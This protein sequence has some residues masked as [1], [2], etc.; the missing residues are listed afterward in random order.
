MLN[1]YELGYAP[2][3][4]EYGIKRYG[5]ETRRLYKVLENNLSAPTS[6]GFL[7]GD[8]LTV[9]DIASWGWICSAAWSGVD[10]KEFPKLLEWR[11]RL[12]A[13]DGFERGRNVP[14][15]QTS[16]KHEGKSEE[17][18]DAA[19]KAMSGWIMKGMADDSKK[20]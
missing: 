16:L 18:L 7:V 12:L 11:T 17:E 8:K 5:N 9:A 20:N 6:K 10:I 15:E 4:I 3:K 19:A 1:V 14:T 2:E 13:R